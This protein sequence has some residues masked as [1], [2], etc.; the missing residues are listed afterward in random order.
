MSPMLEEENEY[1]LYSNVT[2]DAKNLKAPD[3]GKF[4]NTHSAPKSNSFN[5]FMGNTSQSRDD[6]GSTNGESS[7]KNFNVEIQRNLFQT[8]LETGKLNQTKTKRC[9]DNA[10][11]FSQSVAPDPELDLANDDGIKLYD[12]IIKMTQNKLNHISQ[13]SINYE[14]LKKKATRRGTPGGH[15]PSRHSFE[16]TPSR[17]S[18]RY[19]VYGENCVKN[20]PRQLQRSN[21]NPFF[22]CGSLLYSKPDLNTVVQNCKSKKSLMPLQQ[23]Q[24]NYPDTSQ[25]YMDSSFSSGHQKKGENIYKMP[26]KYRD[27]TTTDGDQSVRG[28]QSENMFSSD[29]EQAYMSGYEAV[30]NRKASQKNLFFEKQQQHATHHH[31]DT[32]KDNSIKKYNILSNYNSNNSIPYDDQQPNENNPNNAKFDSQT[33]QKIPSE[34]FCFKK[35]TQ[36]MNCDSPLSQNERHPTAI[37]VQKED[38][39][40]SSDDPS[41]DDSIEIFL[42]EFVEMFHL[43][44]RRVQ[45]LQDESDRV[46]F[47]IKVLD[48]QIENMHDGICRQK[49]LS[50]VEKNQQK[51]QALM[52]TLD[53]EDSLKP[54]YCDL[55][56]C[57]IKNTNIR[58]NAIGNEVNRNIINNFAVVKRIADYDI[59]FKPKKGSEPH[60]PKPKGIKNRSLSHDNFLSVC[61]AKEIIEKDSLRKTKQIHRFMDHDAFFGLKVN[62]KNSIKIMMKYI[63]GLSVQTDK[64]RQAKILKDYQNLS[65]LKTELEHIFRL[66]KSCR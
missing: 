34:K 1:N 39:Q 16:A 35:K 66:W 40:W 64:V 53:C 65:D 60:A 15:T 11:E 59:V 62:Q 33:I 51:V 43:G 54:V 14:K 13:K 50:I 5:L 38:T 58:F 63:E 48:E 26:G 19:S 52:P 20:P 44:K 23:A 29:Y 3:V 2:S 49:V 6:L 56:A 27:K 45:K 25:G 46:H 8:D 10:Y 30:R 7:T 24:H 37:S 55:E 57:M 61:H 21:T 41:L 31:G 12:N 47:E 28:Q 4:S 17:Q 42:E 36:V 9:I 22:G 18:E 32:K